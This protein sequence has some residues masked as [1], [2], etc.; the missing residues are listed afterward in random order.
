MTFVPWAPLGLTVD[1]RGIQL[2]QGSW[3][4]LLWWHLS[5]IEEILS[6]VLLE[7]MSRPLLQHL[8]RCAP[9]KDWLIYDQRLLCGQM[10][11]C[12]SYPGWVTGL[13]VKLAMTGNHRKRDSCLWPHVWTSGGLRS[14]SGVQVLWKDSGRARQ[15]ISEWPKKVPLA[16]YFSICFPVSPLR[17][18]PGLS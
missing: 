10:D 6:N 15:V 5:F 2:Q 12:P 14:K 1:L 9:E 11:V 17:L 4:T 8:T 3:D 18:C 13:N 16:A 7:N